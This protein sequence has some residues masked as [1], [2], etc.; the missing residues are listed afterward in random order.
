[1]QRTA[2]CTQEHNFV[3]AMGGAEGLDVIKGLI[4]RSRQKRAEIKPLDFS[5]LTKVGVAGADGPGH[6]RQH[7]SNMDVTEDASPAASTPSSAP[8][9]LQPRVAVENVRGPAPPAT[10]D[11]EAPR[12]DDHFGADSSSSSTT[13]AARRNRDDTIKSPTQLA[14]EEENV[15][16]RGRIELKLQMTE[17]SKLRKK[18]TEELRRMTDKQ[19]S[20]CDQLLRS[21]ETQAAALKRNNQAAL[22]DHQKETAQELGRITKAQASARKKLDEVFKKWWQANQKEF[23]ADLKQE[24]AGV[25]KMHKEMKE[26]KK[27]I[28]EMIDSIRARR[29]AEFDEQ[30]T[31]CFTLEAAALASKLQIDELTTKVDLLTREFQLRQQHLEE[32]CLL[33]EKHKTQT[34]LEL[35]ERHLL[36]LHAKRAEHQR[37]RHGIIQKQLADRHLSDEESLQKVSCPSVARVSLS[38]HIG[39]MLGAWFVACAPTVCVASL[40][41]HAHAD[42]PASIP[43]RHTRWHD[44]GVQWMS[45]TDPGGAC[46]G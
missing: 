31:R 18:H 32:E 42:I 44:L 14:R 36:V 2:V 24:L 11:A 29:M 9:E 15:L 25:K 10:R 21:Q 12:E 41:S 23:R 45:L 7:N 30:E 28:T 17:I 4:R 34:I 1:M 3:T 35:R 8:A 39:A 33:I 5:A 13:S 20:D 46:G 6:E 16:N 43:S 37:E 26:S 27:S 40:F 19:Q 38:G 22:K